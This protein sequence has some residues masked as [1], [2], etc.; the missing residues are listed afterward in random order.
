MAKK[1]DPAKAK[2]ARQKK[3]AIGLGVLLAGV[4][5]IQ[6][7]KTLKMLKGPQAATVTA[8][9]VPT[10]AP[11]TPAPAAPTPAAPATAAATPAAPA[12][13]QPA[14]LASSD[15]PAAGPGQ[16]E[17][18]ELF[19]SKDPFAQQVDPHAPVV[20]EASGSGN[21]GGGAQPSA[22]PSEPAAPAPAKS[23]A[24]AAAAGGE[25]APSEPAPA[26]A[27]VEAA[28]TV[29]S[30]S[31]NGV[32]GTASVGKEFPESDPIFV[33]VST[34]ADGKS[35]QIG[36]AG[37]TYANGKDTITL[38][39]GKP[40]TLQNTADGTRFELVLESVAGFVTPKKKP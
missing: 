28:A 1:V 10:P 3:I 38:A 20:V 16:L 35:V 6:G 32:P 34:A 8:A 33:L 23:P 2:A 19:V 21:G 17:S 26:P 27:P 30:I 12:T 36:I 13:S 31:V 14:V 39:L 24:P 15:L 4:M 37:G 40:L 9:A 7:P 29:T 11:A 22:K 18:F 25:P 5:A